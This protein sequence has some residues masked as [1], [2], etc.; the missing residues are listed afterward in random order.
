[1]SKSILIVGGTGFIGYHLAKECLKKKWKVTSISLNKPKKTRFLQ[2]VKYLFF[3]ISKK[4]LIKKK[5]KSNFDYV[6]NLGGHVNHSEKIKTFQSHYNGCVN[7]INF[8]EKSKIESFL[9]IGSCVEYGS[10]KSPQKEKY[11]LNFE[12][13]KSSY[14]KAKLKATKY[15]Q[16]KANILNFRINVIRLYLVYGPRQDFNRLIPIVIKGCLKNERFPCSN[17]SQLRD[18]LYVGDAI[19]A[20]LKCLQSKQLNGQILNI[21]FGK[22][23]SVKKVINKINMKIKYGK[24][25]FG[26]IKMR[27]DEIRSL[28]PDIS[29]AKKMINWVPTINFDKGINKTIIY[30]KKY[31]KTSKFKYN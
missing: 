14:G 1:M 9:Q 17:G 20:I 28:Y 12:N 13:L 22:P 30:F 23:S 21:G 25:Q 8:F 26:Y 11:I 19:N 5:L 29:K 7:L 3:D 16:R 27:K 2:N 31:F 4:N 18:F 10:R 24:P 15:L 6:V